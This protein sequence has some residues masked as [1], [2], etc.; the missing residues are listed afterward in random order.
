MHERELKRLKKEFGDV[1]EKL[2]NYDAYIAGGAITS[3]FTN[4][5]INDFDV[6]F[7]SE[8]ELVD[9]IL[10][11]NCGYAVVS[12]TDKATLLIIGTSK[13]QLIRFDYFDNADT[14]FDKFDFTVC[15]GAYGFKNKEFY[16]HEDFFKHNSQKILRFNANTS[17]PYISMLRVEKYRQKGYNISKPELSKIMLSCSQKPLTSYEESIEQLGGM[18]G[19][20]ISNLIDEKDKDN[21]SISKLI[22]KLS[23]LDVSDFNFDM[24]KIS[25]IE[26]EDLPYMI[27][28]E[29]IVVCKSGN[30]FAKINNS[31]NVT[32][33]STISKNNDRFDI[34]QAKDA[35]P[36]GTKLYKYVKSTNKSNEF[37]SFYNN[38]FTYKVGEIVSD[39]KNGLWVSL[40]GNKDELMYGGYKDSI[41]IE[42][43][44]VEGCEF[45][46]F[47]NDCIRATKLKVVGI[48]K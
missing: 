37:N 36:I 6:Y 29:K 11:L 20:N 15:M 38:K 3:I 48:A 16:F 44:V 35:F 19:N 43:E 8:K 42:L 33:S 45:L 31:I 34:I 41:F 25:N 2:E 18:Y 12:H 28:K 4:S 30:D 21:F 23:E 17:Y 40:L 10:D 24:P 32:S 26:P 22:D 13:I 27:S 39:C 7:S 9:F 46:G 1:W 14:I 47:N 5:E